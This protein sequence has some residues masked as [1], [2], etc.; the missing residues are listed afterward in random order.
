MRCPEKRMITDLENS[1]QLSC[2]LDSYHFIQYHWDK[3]HDVLWREPYADVWASDKVIYPQKH[4]SEE[5]PAI[6]ILEAA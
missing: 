4:V 3:L 1:V 6:A 2:D 5:R